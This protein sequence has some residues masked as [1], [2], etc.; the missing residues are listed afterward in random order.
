MR[1]FLFLP[2]ALAF[3]A[4]LLPAQT[5]KMS[6]VFTGRFDSFSL[7]PNGG[8][9]NRIREFDL[10]IATPAPGAAAKDWLPTTA[11][12]ALMGDAFK[13]GNYTR[14][15]K[16]KS[17]F[18]RFNFHG[19]FV[20]YKDMAK[21]DPKLVYFTTRDNKVNKKF[22]VFDKGGT[23]QVQVRPGDFIRFLPGGNIEYFITQDQIMKAAGKQKGGFVKGAGA[24]CQDSKGN[25]YYSPAEG[26]HWVNGK[27]F[28]DAS[29]IM[30]KAADITYDAKGNVKDVKA[31]SAFG[32]L[33]ETNNGPNGQLTLRDMVGN[34]KAV[35]FNGKPIVKTYN[36][37][38]LAL[39]PNGGTWTASHP[40]PK[41]KYLLI[42]NLIFGGDSGGWADTIFSTKGKG[43]IAVINGVLMG[44]HTGKADGSWMG[45]KANAGKYTPT[46]MGFTLIHE[47]KDV[48]TAD[49]P[50]DGAILP[51]DPNITIDVGYCKPGTPL[52]LFMGRGPSGPGQWLSSFDMSASLGAAS[53]GWVYITQP[54]IF[55]FVLGT[56]GTKG[57]GK[58]QVPNPKTPSAAGAVLVFHAA[59]VNLTSPGG[60]SLSNPVLMQFK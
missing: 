33:G 1:K 17:Y 9:L 45:L 12:E 22:L 25:L 50:N 42:P 35:D 2:P 59:R 36:L 34:A 13:D 16:W 3:L 56:A 60:I 40:D 30:I 19:L 44:T 43:S 54:P 46:F 49:A 31:G 27:W 32:I 39:D 14:F 57:Y 28:N 24:L 5:P 38:G 52:F 53:F 29:I 10:G 26:G 58:F 41:G 37:C 55:G 47:V 6:V 48:F 4:A 15:Y 23:V 51:S 8:S 21:G 20:K 11:W 7:D 18:E